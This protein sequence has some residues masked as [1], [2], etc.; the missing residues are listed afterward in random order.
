MADENRFE[1]W[2][3]RRDIVA[4]VIGDPL[5]WSWAAIDQ[6]DR[7]DDARRRVVEVRHGGTPE[8]RV[9]FWRLDVERHFLLIACNQLRDALNRAAR[10]DDRFKPLRAELPAQAIADLRNALEHRGSEG[11]RRKHEA[12]YGESP[13]AHRWASTG[14]GVLG[15]AVDDGALRGALVAIHAALLDIETTT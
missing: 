8:G 4:G 3:K 1:E 10:V 14:G 5:R 13:D 9:R 6:L 15:G 2:H 12:H 7:L 11:R